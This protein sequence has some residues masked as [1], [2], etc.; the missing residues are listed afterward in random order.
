TL[1]AVGGAKTSS[2]LG[3]AGEKHYAQG[4]DYAAFWADLG[5]GQVFTNQ[6]P[7]VTKTG[8]TIWM[9]ATYAP[10]LAADGTVGG[11]V[12]VA[13]D[14]TARRRGLAAIATGLEAL[15]EGDLGARVAVSDIT[16]IGNLGKAFNQSVEQL[17]VTVNTAKQV[18]EG[19]GQTAGEISQSSSDLSHRTESQAATLEETAA[20]LEQL[21]ST[22]QAAANGAKK[23]EEIV[24]QAQSVAVH[25][26]TVVS[27]AIDAMSK[28]EGSSEEIAKIITVI[29]DIAFQTNL[30][31]L[32]AGV[33]AARAGEAGRGFAVVASEVRGLAQRSAGAAGEIKQLIGE[34]KHHVGS[35]V[36]LVGKTGK[37]LQRIIDSVGT[38]SNHIS[39]IAR[40]AAE[41]ST[42]LVEINTGVTQLDQVTQQ[43]AAMVE[44]T[45][46][47]S[48]TLSND[49]GQ[50][51]RQLGVFKTK[52]IGVG[53]VVQMPTAMSSPDV[54]ERSVSTR[55][56]EQ[57]SS[58]TGTGGQSAG[59][60]RGWEDF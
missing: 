44:Q 56:S 9:Q 37:E 19:V 60:A 57:A 36:D 48:L 45:T 41:Q 30:L 39:E 6:Y 35:G 31:A 29:D 1:V 13:T 40:G 59:A 18:S 53:N 46:A 25:S 43:N 11:V 14:V 49:A 24:D 51:T 55:V 26:G 5:R 7:R 15:R 27:D 4:E 23:V 33:E 22:V 20:A 50:L 17:E 32:N 2:Y 28:I 38:I 54:R 8:E 21:T 10:W 16:D 34:S 3:N 52:P 12:T 47:A 42:T 58:M